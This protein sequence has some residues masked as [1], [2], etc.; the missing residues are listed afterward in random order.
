MF[1]WIK[2]FLFEDR[3]ET[4]ASLI[5]IHQE[6]ISYAHAYLDLMWYTFDSYYLMNADVELNYIKDDWTGCMR[7]AYYLKRDYFVE[8]SKR[9]F[10]SEWY[11][12][13]GYDD[14]K[15][16]FNVINVNWNKETFSMDS[17]IEYFNIWPK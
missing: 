15:N 12:Y 4:L 7:D 8:I 16:V 5:E 6:A 14:L 13:I 10:I 3:D 9:W 11:K 2:N 17:A 1:D